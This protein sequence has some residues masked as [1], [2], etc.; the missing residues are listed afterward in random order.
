VFDILRIQVI[1]VKDAYFFKLTR[2]V[3]S[4]DKKRLHILFLKIKNSHILCI[5]KK[6]IFISE[7]PAIFTNF[8]AAAFFPLFSIVFKQFEATWP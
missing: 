1:L 7:I 6:A 4:K 8:V 2:L 5:T 3:V